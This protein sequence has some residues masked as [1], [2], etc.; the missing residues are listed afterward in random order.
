MW[1]VRFRFP[2]SWLV[3]G[4][5][6]CGKTTKVLNFIKH[7]K[8]MTN[9]PT[10]DNIV[11]YYNQWQEAYNSPELKKAGVKWVQGLPTLEKIKSDTYVSKD[12]GSI[13]VID[14]FAHVAGKDI[15]ELFTVYAH[16]GNCS[17]IFLSQN[18]FDKNPVF[19]QISLNSTYISVFKNPRDKMQINAFAKQIH[20]TN[21]KFVIESF[22]EATKKPFSYMLFDNHQMTPDQLRIRSRILPD[23][24]PMIIWMDKTNT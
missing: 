24:A 19:R 4:G 2:F 22:L 9:N 16:H 7:H 5:S 1:D 23:E 8:Q 20:P 21:S 6:G 14:D 3:A 12:T 18:L 13:I 11:Y 10:C 17:C 15:L